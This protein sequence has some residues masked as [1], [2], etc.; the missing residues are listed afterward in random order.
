[1]TLVLDLDETLLHTEFEPF[2]QDNQKQLV[3]YVWE[4][5]R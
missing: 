5:P 4:F 2:H 3:E 1:M